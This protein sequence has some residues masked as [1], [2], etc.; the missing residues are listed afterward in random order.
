MALWS[1]AFFGTT[2]IGGPIIGYI[3]DHANPR[4]GLIVGGASAIIAAGLA[5]IFYRPNKSGQE[6]TA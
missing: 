3:C 5:F 6:Q 1:V 2:P 4:I